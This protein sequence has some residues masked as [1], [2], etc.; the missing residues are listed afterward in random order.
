MR[1]RNAARRPELRFEVADARSLSLT[2]GAYDVILDKGLLDAMLCAC[3]AGEGVAAMVNAVAAGLAPGGAFMVV[4][5]GAP[6]DRLHWVQHAQ[7]GWTLD[8]WTLPKPGAKDV[9]PQAPRPSPDA[10]A[11]QTDAPAGSGSASGSSTPAEAP[12]HDGSIRGVRAARYVPGCERSGTAHFV[13]VYKRGD[14]E[15]ATPAPAPADTLLP[16]TFDADDAA[17][18]PLPLSDDAGARRWAF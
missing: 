3:N 15:T 17:P 14:T 12:R 7:R 11:G 2:P 13:Y 6:C 5:F 4:S 10:P 1:S 9:M 16:A 18:M 8:I